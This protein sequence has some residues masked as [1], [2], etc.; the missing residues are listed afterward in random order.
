MSRIYWVVEKQWARHHC[1]LF[2]IIEQSESWVQ[3][4]INL[5]DLVILPIADKIPIFLNENR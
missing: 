4:F 5:T 2:K 1:I 3:C